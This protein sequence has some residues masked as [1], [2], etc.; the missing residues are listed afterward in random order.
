MTLAQNVAEL[1][2]SPLGAARQVAIDEARPRFGPDLKVT[3]PVRGA[4]RLLRTQNG[5]L[6]RARL[7]TAVELECSR[8]LEP[9]QRELEIDL[10]EEFRPSVHIVTGVP[11]DAPDDEALLIDEHHVLDLTEAVRQYISTALPLQPLCTPTCRGLCATCGKNLNEGPCG[12]ALE[13]APA[14]GP[15]AALA[16]LIEKI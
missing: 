5:V 9:V 10:A 2:K 1:L 8:C 4:A 14:T 7:T 13:P 12:C 11:L 3:S 15:F 16:G 6:V